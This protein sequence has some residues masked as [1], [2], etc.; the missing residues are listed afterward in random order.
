MAERI[1]SLGSKIC[2]Q[3]G[4]KDIRSTS[5]LTGP[6]IEPSVFI[7]R[8]VCDSEGR[9]NAHSCLLE[10]VWSYEADLLKARLVRVVLDLS[11]SSE[12][13]SICLFPGQVRGRGGGERERE[14]ER[15]GEGKICYHP[16]VLQTCV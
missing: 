5:L 2:Q 3:I 1:I 4:I 12:Q 9:L 11:K 16:Q 8:V 7:G 15:G 14:R 13:L 6:T 10:G